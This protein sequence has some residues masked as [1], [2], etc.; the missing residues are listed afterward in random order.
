[1]VSRVR[2]VLRKKLVLLNSG[3]AVG[4]TGTSPSLMSSPLDHP[5]TV[6]QAWA[7]PATAQGEWAGAAFQLRLKPLLKPSR[8]EP[9]FSLFLSD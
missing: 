3:V 2:Q 7:L 8:A 9:A 4:V 6:V 1:M 5:Y